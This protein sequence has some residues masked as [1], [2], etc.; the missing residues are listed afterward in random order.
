MEISEA[1]LEK[2]MGFLGPPHTHCKS[3]SRWGREREREKVRIERYMGSPRCCSWV[4]VFPAQEPTC[5]WRSFCMVWG[6]LWEDSEE[7]PWETGW[8]RGV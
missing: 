8:V 3:Q 5:G 6:W 2:A 1:A 7:H 4:S